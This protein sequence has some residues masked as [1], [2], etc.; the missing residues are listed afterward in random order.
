MRKL[1]ILYFEDNKPNDLYMFQELTNQIRGFYSKRYICKELKEKEHINNPGIYF[2]IAHYEDETRIYVG[3]SQN[4][5][6]RIQ[7]H[8]IKKDF[9]D[10]CY[11][12][13]TD[14]NSFNM[15]TVDY[16]EHL[17][18]QKVKKSSYFVENV[19]ERTQE[20]TVTDFDLP[21]IDKSFEQIKFLLSCMG[22]KFE[23]KLNKEEIHEK[24]YISSKR[25]NC[26]LTYSDG[27]FILLNG[28][29]LIRPIESS[30]EWSDNGRFYNRF[31]K[32]ID[33]LL[34]QKK[35]IEENDKILLKID[36]PFD[37]PSPAAEICSG[38]AEN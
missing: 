9:W 13:V 25:K 18:I 5:F 1:D 22:I 6:Q 10:E 20:P 4:I 37:S 24:I 31:N 12:F 26:K 21:L 35:A 3:K 17:F 8:I 16:L 11:I 32:L 34:E 15:A 14:N 30:K 29:Q 2:L 36:Y 19:I 27:K 38:Y 23:G 33:E 28:S 7:E